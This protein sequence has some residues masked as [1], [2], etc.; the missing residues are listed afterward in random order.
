MKEKELLEKMIKQGRLIMFLLLAILIV[1]SIGVTKLYSTND[2]TSNTETETSE[3]NTEYDVSMFKEIESKDLKKETKGKLSVVYIG[4]ETCGWCAA[5]LPNLWA[6]QEEY[7]FT[8]LYID[9]A[10]IIDFSTGEVT[11]QDDYDLLASITG[12]GYETYMNE[13]LGATPMVLIMK[14]N[15]IIG[16]QTGYSEYEAFETVLTEAGVKK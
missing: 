14:D 7:N 12:S 4:R 8:T 15:K 2:N 10:K 9:I 1:L 3:Y 5:F 13:N 11:N 6:A 16:A